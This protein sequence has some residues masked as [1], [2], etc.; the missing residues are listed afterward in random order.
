MFETTL[1]GGETDEMPPLRINVPASRSGHECT[2][3]HGIEEEELAWILFSCC[4]TILLFVSSDVDCVVRNQN[5]RSNASH[6]KRAE[7]RKRTE[8]RSF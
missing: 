8:K 2:A 7:Y 3:Q 1:A 5:A 4:S 6:I